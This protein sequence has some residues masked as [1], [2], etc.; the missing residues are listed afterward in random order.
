MFL[1][2]NRRD[3]EYGPATLLDGKS[4]QVFHMKPLAYENDGI[5]L[6]IRLI[7]DEIEMMLD[8]NAASRFRRIEKRAK[9]EFNQKFFARPGRGLP[10]RA[11][12]LSKAVGGG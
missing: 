7:M 2:G 6:G 4:D 8:S 12:D 10:Q 3:L 1:H 5:R 9:K 11:P